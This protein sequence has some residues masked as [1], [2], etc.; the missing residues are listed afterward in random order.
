MLLPV[1][2]CQLEAPVRCSASVMS[3]A[4]GGK[5]IRLSIMTL[6][7]VAA[8]LVGCRSAPPPTR[9]E[10]LEK[11]H[12]CH[13]ELNKEGATGQS[14]SHCT[15]L[16]P[17]PL[18][19]ISRAELAA[20]LGPPAFCTGLSEG[21]APHGPDCPPQLDPTWFFH[22]VGSAGPE[23]HCETDQRQRCEVVLWIH[24]D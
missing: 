5:M 20:A 19:G 16:D 24:S 18:N 21:H 23:L 11:L 10:L 22:R 3:H 9:A 6:S 4:R 2:C 7:L 12:Q 17:S 13:A 14:G 8:A 1:R 15:T